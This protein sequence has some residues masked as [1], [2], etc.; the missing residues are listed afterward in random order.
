MAIEKKTRISIPKVNKVR[1][2]LQREI[3]SACPFCDSTDVGHFEIHHIDEN[4]SNNENGNLLLLC[5]TCH[6]KITKGDIPVTEVF[7]KKISLIQNSLLNQ[8]KTGKVITFNG[9]VNAPV[10]GDNNNV[11]IKNIRKSTK[12]KYP[13]GCI[14]FETVKANYIG[15]LIQR[16]NEYKEYEVSKGKVNYA[17]FSSHLKKQYKI[18]A[19]RT[20]YN[21]PTEKFEDLVSYI[22]SRIN[23]T[24][25][26]KIKGRGHKNYSTFEEYAA[27]QK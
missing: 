26:A 5:P 1:A 23:S 19:T 3:A 21:L 2:E 11:S 18:G 6:S 17:V 9:T 27:M 24:K 12:Q 22:H 7:K 14:G 20:L 8:P 13:E 15:H 10:V 16:Y 4:P 25:L